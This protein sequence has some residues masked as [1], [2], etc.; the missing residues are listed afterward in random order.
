MSYMFAWQVLSPEHHVSYMWEVKANVADA[1]H[2][3]DVTFSVAYRA[4]SEAEAEADSNEEAEAWTSQRYHA[5]VR[6]YQVS[7]MP[8]PHCRPEVSRDTGSRSLS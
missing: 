5:A 2:G 8:S 3:F 6:N 7:V 1:A 4:A